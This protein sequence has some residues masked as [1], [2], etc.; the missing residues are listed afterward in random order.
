MHA[1]TRLIQ[2]DSGSGILL[3][4]AAVLAMVMANSPLADVYH[5]LIELPVEVRVGPL[6]LAKPLLLWVNDGLMA[7]FFFMVGL[8]LKR[9]FIDGQLSDLRQVT[10]PAMGALGGMVVPSVIYAS[11]NWNDPFALQG[12]AIPAATDIAFAL[13]ILTLFGRRVPVALKLLLV[14]IA[15]FDDVGAIVIIAL[16][17]T[18]SLS[19]SALMIA[20]TC[21]IV[22]FALNQLK[23]TKITPYILVGVVM[24][25]AVLKSGVHATLAGVLLAMFIPAKDTDDPDHCPLKG[26]ERDLHGVVT[27]VIL[28]LFA[29]ANSGITINGGGL[30]YLLHP[31][32]VGIAAGLFFGK[33]I[34]VMLACWISVRIGLAQLPKGVNWANLYGIA[35]LCGIGFTMSLFIGS[36]AF[37][38]SVSH[39]LFDERLGIIIGSTI[40]GIV[41]Y[42]YLRKVLPRD[43][44]AP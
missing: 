3:F 41:G 18:D 16:F 30:G 33:Q 31:I 35:I 24:W 5:L 36:L 25:I 32:P 40:S 12:W 20:V 42:L 4:S 13:A 43:G 6:I 26:L 19:P 14:S 10:L 8:E 38:D 23:V 37:H 22:L 21:L 34:G 28:P 39:T 29:F 27:F 9:E 11:L 1:F 44:Q 17:Y 2:S 7:I 15:I